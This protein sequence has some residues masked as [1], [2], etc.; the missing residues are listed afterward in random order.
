MLSPTTIT[1]L[2]ALATAAPPAGADGPGVADAGKT[3]VGVASAGANAT[4]PASGSA[5]PDVAGIRDCKDS[6]DIAIFQSPRWPARNKPLRILIA[7]EQELPDARL[8]V[9]TPSGEVVEVPVKRY[10][11]PPWGFVGVIERPKLGTYVAALGNGARVDACQKMRVRKWGNVRDSSP[12]GVDP[13]W[14][15]RIKW[16]RDTENLYSLWVE[17]LFD[18]PPDEDIS[19]KR[20]HYVTRDAKRNLLYNHLGMREDR[21]SREAMK[22]K[23]DCADFPYF[24]RA[25]F[26][27]KLGLPFG[28]RGCIRGNAKRAPRCGKM[29]SHHQA[30]EEPSKTKAFEWFA[31]KKIA[32][33][34]HSSSL[35]TLPKSEASDLY[36]VA[37][38]RKAL[39]PGTVYTDPYGHTF[40]VGKWV[41]QKGDTAGTLIAVDAQPDGTIGRRTFWKGSFLFP[42]DDA[43]KGAGWK[44]FRPVRY[45]R[46]GYRQLTNSEIRASIDYGD[47]STEQWDN[48]NEAFYEA[49]DALITPKPLPP[50]KALTAAIEALYQQVR[51]R[52]ESVQNGE[53][54][55]RKNPGRTMRMPKGGAIFLT[56]G[57]WED[58]STPSRDMRL[59]IAMDVVTY[60]HKRVQKY[61]K[62]FKLPAGKSVDQ[63]VAD[64]K[65]LMVKLTKERPVEYKRSDGSKWKLTLYDVMQREKQFEASYNPND[66]VEQRWGAD[67]TSDEFK[68]CKTAA[69]AF[70]RKRM[71]SYRGWFQ[72]RQRPLY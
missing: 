61:P 45:T 9:K 11:G 42:K 47:F 21:T 53:D 32:G 8:A 71:E 7:S 72:K 16:E 36:P 66:C 58:Y 18:A 6:L 4:K 50:D 29:I 64:M 15:A 40:M 70:Q 38:T 35:R 56:A 68:T 63:V 52:V 1:A 26:A 19:W 12:D 13:V 28:Y 65:Q 30:S 3:S 54:W 49:M 5:L 31:R 33:T 57:P 48:G 41:P 2:L 51:R 24:T 10:G 59:L 69:P 20:L 34:V 46:T 43:V 27:W 17:H 55:K 44:R 67:P 25:Y 14:R 39:R 62:R 22:L 23:P 60:F 37:L